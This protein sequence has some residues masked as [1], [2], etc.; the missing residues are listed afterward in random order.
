MSR[1]LALLATAVVGLWA[2]LPSSSLAAEVISAPERCAPKTG[3]SFTAARYSMSTGESPVV[4]MPP[5]LDFPHDVLSVDSAVDGRPLFESAPVGP[6][7]SAAVEGAEYLNPGIY[8]FICSIHKF[9]TIYGTRME[10]DLVVL[11][12]GAPPKSRQT[13][14]L[15]LPSQSLAQVLQ[16]GMAVT[17]RSDQGA[18]QVKIIARVG[19]RLVATATG[20]TLA[21]GASRSLRMRLSRGAREDLGERASAVV[22]LVGAAR[23]GEPD[24]V[25]QRL[26]R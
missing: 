17:I 8:H 26:G 22:S 6:G 21:P 24:A 9:P 3:C 2:A 18:A 13:I 10:A 14:D 25:R 5:I 16:R 11:D 12:N 7:R 15:E 20:L 23:F 19:K 1:K 4:S